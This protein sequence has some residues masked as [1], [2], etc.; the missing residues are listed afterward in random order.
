MLRQVALDG[1]LA[2]FFFLTFWSLFWCLFRVVFLKRFLEV[3][4]RH[5]SFILVPKAL[6]REVFWSHFDDFL[7][8]RWTMPKPSKTNEIT[9]FCR[10]GPTPF[11]TLFRCFFIGTD[12]RTVFSYIFVIF[13]IL[14]GPRQPIGFQNEYQ[15]TPEN[16]KLGQLLGEGVQRGSRGGF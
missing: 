14:G 7:R 10:V 6:Q 1:R 8:T 5:F 2:D 3:S 13:S 12:F 9:R 15:T 11:S 4:G 16:Q